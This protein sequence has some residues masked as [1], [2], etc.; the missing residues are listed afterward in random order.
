MTPDPPIPDS[1]LD[2]ELKR[3]FAAERSEGEHL[4]PDAAAAY[5]AG[6]LDA[7]ERERV[8][9]HVQRCREC[10]ALVL[11]IETLTGEPQADPEVA[12]LDVA[13]AWR[14]LR[15]RLRGESPTALRSSARWRPGST[16]KARCAS[17]STKPT[18]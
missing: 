16:V 10:A 6:D 9:R 18:F 1:T 4:D 12:D 8:A 17:T 3:V 11:D 2:A 13:A 14:S 15:P 5:L 7:D